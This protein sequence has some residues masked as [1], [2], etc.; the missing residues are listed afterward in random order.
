MTQYQ[1][2]CIRKRDRMS[3]HEHITH[4]GNG[5]WI[6]TREEV[7]RLIDSGEATFYVTD[8]RT[9]KTSW[10]GVVRPNDGR[11]PFIRTHADSLWNDN[12]LS[13]PEC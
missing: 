4:V 10:V 7:I 11:S 3:A 8:S 9:G 6:I 5:E 1:I 12:L 2:T 13:L